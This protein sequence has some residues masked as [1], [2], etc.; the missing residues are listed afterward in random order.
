MQADLIIDNRR[1]A[2]SD[3]GTFERRNPI[4]GKVVSTAAAGTVEDA[5]RAADVAG[6]A[7]AEWSQVGPTERRSILLAA[8]G[9]LEARAD[10]IQVAMAEEI[11]ASAMWS[12]VNVAVAANLIRE[13]AALTTQMVGE[14]IPTDRPGALSFTVRQPVGAVLSM[15]PWN[16]PIL[17]GARSIAYPLACGNTVVFRGSELS[18]RTHLLLVE[19]FHEGGVPPG[20]LNLIFNAPST[21]PEAIESLIDHPAI[22]RVNFTGSTRVGRVIAEKA[23]RALKRCLLEL[24]GKAP[25]VVL[26]DADV[27]SA[28]KAAN[29]GAFLFQGQICMTTERVVVDESVADAFVEAFARRADG[30]AVGDPTVDPSIIVGP[31]IDDRSGARINALIRDALDKGATLVAG[32]YAEGTVMRPTILDR[33]TPEMAIYDEES[34]GPVTI[35]V[36]VKGTEEATRVA[37]D[38][39]YGLAASV[40]GQ[41]T[42]RALQVAR[43]IDAGAVHVNGA[44]MQNEPQA[45]YGGM[46]ASGY[47][48]FDGRAVIDEFTELKW[49]T[50]EAADQPYPI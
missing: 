17:L 40:F 6:N 28:A 16:G 5:R 4:S 24:G 49:L 45:P 10:V 29:F 11:G 12:A 33:C 25:F 13:A 15:A 41:D 19:A 2:A 9:C 7:F 14:T 3:G 18:P 20:V 26:D 27:E 43:R 37:N 23:G 32:G 38:T 44:T 36:R 1:V 34:F 46:K 39:Q 8:A 42:Y 31:V 30:L 35:V 48:R 50:I 21:A 47:G 22:R